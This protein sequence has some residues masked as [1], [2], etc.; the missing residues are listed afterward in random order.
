MT[1]RELPS[2]PQTRGG[3]FDTETGASAFSSTRYLPRRDRVEKSVPALPAVSM[4]AVQEVLDALPGSATF[5]LPVYG[6][7]GEVTDFRITAASPDAVDVGARKGRELVGL[8]VRET[9]PSVVGSE[10]WQGY[11]TALDTGLRY[12]SEPF[13]YEE[14]VAGVSRR[15]R[16]AVRAAS[17][18]AGLIVSW[19]SM[20]DAERDQRR[21]RAMQRLARMGW[22]DWDLVRNA[23]TWSDEVYAVF[24]RDPAL[25]PMALEE[26]PGHVVAED[27]PALGESVRLLLGDGAPID[28]TFRVTGSQGQV[29]HVRIVA[30]ADVD[31]H[32]TPVEV[33]GFFQDLTALKQA[34]EQL[35]EHE[36]AA[37]AH[38][39]LLEAERDLA[40]R[41]Q[42]ALLPLPQQSLSLAGLTV[43]VAYQPLQEG[44][45]VGG[46]WYSAIEL[47]DGSAL[48]VVG[49]VAGHG[50]DAVATMAQLRF[51]AKGM[52][53]T[54]TPLPQILARLNTLLL[55]GSERNFSTATMVMARYEPDSSRFT[56]VQAGHLPPLL[57]RDGEARFLTA[58]HGVLLGAVPTPRYDSASVQLLPGDQ[59]L[60]YTD[61]LVEEPGED[62]TDGLARLS[63]TAEACSGD[64]RVLDGILGTLVS[65]DVRRDDICVLHVGLTPA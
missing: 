42:H 15:S 21:L 12:E 61:G 36:R 23:V 38:R 57:V 25:G 14:V 50:L 40:A 20:D 7:R 33:H 30:E 27:L 4:P 60:L 31:L 59:L 35:L 29:R 10:L 55:H 18:H 65:P 9:Y 5:L 19:V 8:S 28:H 1:D 26:L 63:R 16:L 37:V 58:P 64:A 6:A 54:G 32:G 62:I 39:S 34:Q 24:D 13:D 44:L 47:S 3:G 46:D 2:V 17:C 52:A 45:N 41:L 49:D 51:T 56:W 22:A 11:L 43:D 53:I 48:L